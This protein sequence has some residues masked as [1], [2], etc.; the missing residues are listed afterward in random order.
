MGQTFKDLR[1]LIGRI[2]VSCFRCYEISSLPE[3][4]QAYPI[5]PVDDWT[6]DTMGDVLNVD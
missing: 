2:D 5:G 3:L 1:F 4:Q 6:V